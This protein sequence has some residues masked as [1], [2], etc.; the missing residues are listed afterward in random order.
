MSRE[1]PIF[2]DEV[3][4]QIPVNGL[5]VAIMIFVG[6]GFLMTFLRRYSYSAVGLNFF[7]SCLVMLAAILAV[8]CAQQVGFVADPAASSCKFGKITPPLPPVPLFPL[9]SSGEVSK[10]YGSPRGAIL[11]VCPHFRG[12]PFWVSCVSEEALKPQTCCSRQ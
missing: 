8:G 7:C 9:L 12:I 2:K 10:T 6:F 5:Q 11:S 4:I 3:F 1:I